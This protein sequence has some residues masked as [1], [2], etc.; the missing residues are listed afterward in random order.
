[1]RS[2]VIKRHTRRKQYDMQLCSQIVMT[3]LYI[4][5]GYAAAA[6]A[7]AAGGG[8]RNGFGK[9]QSVTLSTAFAEC[10][11]SQLSS[12]YPFSDIACR[13]QGERGLLAG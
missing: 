12:K 9:W 11:Q 13:C 10:M 6:A 3:N 8:G 2:A 4:R 5:L 1:M 7:I